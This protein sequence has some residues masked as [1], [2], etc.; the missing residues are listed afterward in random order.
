VKWFVYNPEPIDFWDG[1]N[2]FAG[3]VGQL[4][5]DDDRSSVESFAHEY[6][7][8]LRAAFEAGYDGKPRAEIGYVS[9]LPRATHEPYG[10]ARWYFA[11]KA[12]NNGDT[13]VVSPYAL[14]WM[15]FAKEVTR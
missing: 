2:T 6:A 14:P 8:A 13:Y 3:V 10:A 9:V 12:D 1:W 4:S 5:H 11:F 15:G 7:S